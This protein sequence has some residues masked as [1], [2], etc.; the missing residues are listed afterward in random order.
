MFFK[1]NLAGTAIL[2]N[3][4]FFAARDHIR[5]PD[6]LATPPPNCGVDLL[7]TMR[8][9]STTTAEAE[10][11]S[12]D[13]TAKRGVVETAYARTKGI[14]ISPCWR[15]TR[16]VARTQLDFVVTWAFGVHNRLCDLRDQ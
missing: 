2:A 4:H 15:P 9:F 3:T 1:D 16:E 12:K 8:G 13:I 10:K 6:I 5:D 14:F 11:K 7:L